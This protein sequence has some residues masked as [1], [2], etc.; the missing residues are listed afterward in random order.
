VTKFRLEIARAYLDDARMLFKDKWFNSA[1]SRAYYASYQAMWAA[2]G[3]PEE[4]K[5]WRHLGIIKHFVAGY[6]FEPAPKRTGPGLLEDKRLPLRRLYSYRIRSDY[7]AR[8][9]DKNQLGDLL[10]TV[11]HGYPTHKRK[12]EVK[13]CRK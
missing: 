2:L 1:A 3:E 9:V 10:E 12:S 4:G 8:P 13:K 11:E 7:E 6:W 5:V